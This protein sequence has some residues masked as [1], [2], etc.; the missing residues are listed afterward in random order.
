MGKLKIEYSDKKITPFGG[1]KLLKDFMDKTSVIDDLQS[2]NLPQGYSNA[3]YD[4]VDIF[5]QIGLDMIQLYNQY[6]ISRDYRHNQPTV[7]FFINLIWRK[8]VKYF[9]SYSKNFFLK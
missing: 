4:P 7:D 3:A 2:V 9:H 1:M 6:L 8:I 5:M